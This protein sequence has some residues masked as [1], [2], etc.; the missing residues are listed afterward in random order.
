MRELRTPVLLATALLALSCSALQVSQDYDV[1]ADL[2]DLATFA[3]MSEK[4]AKTGD[5]RSDN[6]L[7]DG[8]IRAA[9]ERTLAA[10][11]FRKQSGGAVD[12]AVSY[13]FQIRTKIG[14]DRVR[15]GVGFGFGSSGSFGGVGVSTGTGVSQYDEGL[16]V[17]DITEPG[18]G[19]LLWRGTGVRPMP[20]KSD[21]QEITADIDETVE[22]VLAQ[23]PPPPK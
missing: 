5:V 19:K 17:I 21:P 8:R 11:G 23:F 20:R 12:F 22:K 9:V 14:S 16:L 4:Q 3:W 7:L 10:K 15:T 13:V 18:S 6:P 1:N 2:S